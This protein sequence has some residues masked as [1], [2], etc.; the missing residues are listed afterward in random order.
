MHYQTFPV[1]AKKADEFVKK[2]NEK[3]PEV[4]VIV[5][6]LGETYSL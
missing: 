6:A 3:S 5:L 1:L 4:K 2:V